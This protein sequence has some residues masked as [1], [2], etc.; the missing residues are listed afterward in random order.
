MKHNHYIGRRVISYFPDPAPDELLYSVCA[1]FQNQVQYSDQKFVVKELFGTSNA[2]AVVDLPSHLDSLIAALPLG[3]RYSA[4]RLI[5]NQTL[6][7]FYSPFHQP[8]RVERLREDLRGNGKISV[9]G[10]LGIMANSVP[11]PAWLRFCPLCTEDDERQFGE[12][13]WHRIHQVPGVK[14]CP[15]H[16]V[17]LENSKAQVLHR[18]T[19][20]EYISAQQ[21]IYTTSPRS[22]T[23]SNLSHVALLKIARDAAWLLNQQSLAP[24]LESFRNRY[25]PLLADRELATYS[26]RV[27]TSR[28]LDAFQFYYSE[29]LLRLLHCEIDQQSQHNWLFRL[30]RS[31]KSAQHP[32]HHLLLIQFL[33]H[34]AESFFQ[35]PAEYQPFGRGSWPCLNPVCEQFR[36]RRI[37][38]YRLS[39]SQENGRPIGTFNCHCCGFVYSRIG[40]DQSMEDWYRYSRVES[41]G[42]VWESTLK[43]WWADKGVSLR[44][45]ARR[46]EVDPHTVKSH[47]TR[48]E[49]LFPRPTKRPTQQPTEQLTTEPGN[50]VTIDQNEL[51]MNR[52]AWLSLREDNPEAGG[53]LLRSLLPR[54]YIWLYRNDKEWLKAYMPPRKPTVSP[55]RVDW[56]S[57]DTQWAIAAKLSA[58]H[59]KNAP[60]RPVQITVAAIARDIGQ[61]AN[62]QKHLDQLPLTAQVL[63]EVVETREQFAVRRVEYAAEHFRQENV[64]PQRWQLVRRAG[65]RPDMEATQQVKEAIATALASLDP[66]GVVQTDELI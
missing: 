39:Y 38:N 43:D 60:G 4:D 61:L 33:G 51:E 13:Y 47:A 8:A 16:A 21:A 55:S 20:H 7:P 53:K 49:L 48:L 9:P 11:T 58:E 19:R 66:L 31:P 62:I 24:G 59:L 56:E 65:L 23:L 40:P 35:L 26:G 1:R 22:L 44:E 18:K 37:K 57:R 29:E 45:I 32:L 28:L 41:Y 2:I 42:G 27:Y 64:C 52:A 25:L 63:A 12:T 15:V 3:N 10:R 34:T 17:F 30:V 54:V 14:V 50:A 6:L 5:D 46:L 36:R